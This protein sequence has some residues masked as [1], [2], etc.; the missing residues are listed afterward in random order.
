MVGMKRTHRTVYFVHGCSA[1]VFDKHYAERQ[2]SPPRELTDFALVESISRE[3][4][5]KCSNDI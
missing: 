3:L 1:L 5:G 2:E 4:N